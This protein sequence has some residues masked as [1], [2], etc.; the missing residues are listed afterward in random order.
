MKRIGIATL[1]MSPAMALAHPGHAESGFWSGFIHPFT[2]LD[3]LAV[4]FGLGVL[5][6]VFFSSSKLF[7]KMVL[8][9][10]IVSLCVGAALANMGLMIPMLE[11]IILLSVLFVGASLV[12]GGLVRSP[13]KWAV[14][15]LA[16]LATFHGY[17]HILES[18]VGHGLGLYTL[19]FVSSSAMLYIGGQVLGQKMQRATN[20]K[21]YC[22]V[23][24]GGYILLAL[25]LGL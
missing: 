22:V 17:V 1:M 4:M 12:F 10:L 13:S 25:L 11:S 19:G 14:C 24:G 6:R 23:S 9:I 18:S 20:N 2:G 15:G 8:G 16:A 5:C 3:H 21:R 7:H